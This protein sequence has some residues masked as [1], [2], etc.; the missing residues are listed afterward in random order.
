[1][2]QIDLNDNMVP[3][4]EEF[5]TYERY[6]LG[7]RMG[8][9]EDY[10]HDW[11]TFIEKL[12]NDYETR[13]NYL[14]SHR[15]APINW[16]DHILRVLYPG[17]KSAQKYGCSP[18]E[19]LKLLNLGVIEHDVA[20]QTWLKQQ[21]NIL[22]YLV[23]RIPEEAARYC[24]R[25]FWFVSRQLNSDRERGEFSTIEYIAGEWESLA[26]QLMTRKL[27]DIDPTKGLFTLAQMLC[28]GSILPPWKF[29]LS[30]DDCTESC[31]M[32]MGYAD[33]FDLWIRCA[34]DDDMLLRKMLE[35]TGIPGDWND[36]INENAI[37]SIT[38]S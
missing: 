2:T 4:W 5:P 1:M 17:I 37:F 10:F 28:A 36:W 13:L 24:L 34:F 6:T 12:P 19:I 15:P 21:T 31:E 11:R 33:A 38:L 20:Y 23:N 16:G 7:W 22:P 8:V 30:P 32:D 14:K 9:G 18:A 35:K 3:P 29:G 27:G 26:S 25:D